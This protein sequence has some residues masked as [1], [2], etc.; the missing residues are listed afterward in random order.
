MFFETF[1][2]QIKLLN[3][4]FS[5][6]FFS[7]MRDVSIELSFSST[8]FKFK[9]LSFLKGL[10]L[11][12]YFDNYISIFG[13]AEFCII[14]DSETLQWIS[15]ILHIVQIIL[16]CFVYRLLYNYAIHRQPPMVGLVSQFFIHFFRRWDFS[17]VFLNVH[18]HKSYHIY[19]GFWW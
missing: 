6:N 18:H 17:A 1:I 9:N 11:L 12:S 16:K 2:F 7:P 15:W 3:C 10:N 14:Q 19:V 5:D 8:G 4:K 13:N